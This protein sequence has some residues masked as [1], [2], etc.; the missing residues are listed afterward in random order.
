[1]FL[2][3]VLLQGHKAFEGDQVAQRD[4]VLHYNK[5]LGHTTLSFQQS[6]TKECMV[7]VLHHFLAQP[8]PS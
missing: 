3:A 2:K 1:M 6:L 5:A 4:Y 8:S 7:S